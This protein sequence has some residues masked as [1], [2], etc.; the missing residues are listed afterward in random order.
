MQGK[1]REFQPAFT[2]ASKPIAPDIGHFSPL[3]CDLTW[4]ITGNFFR[5]CRVLLAP[6]RDRIGN[7]H[8]WLTAHIAGRFRVPCFQKPL[9]RFLAGINPQPI[10]SLPPST[11]E[12]PPSTR[13]TRLPIRGRSFD[14]TPPDAASRSSKPKRANIYEIALNRVNEMG[15]MLPISTMPVAY[16]HGTD[17]KVSG[18]QLSATSLDVTGLMFI[19]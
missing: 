1:Y 15:Y 6:I 12:C 7:H 11:S 17:V 8:S 9:L 16:A 19:H 18:H 3:Q 4:K 10:E 14:N 2:I 13:S 5:M